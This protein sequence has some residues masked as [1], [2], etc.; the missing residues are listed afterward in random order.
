MNKMKLM[1]F[2]TSLFAL[3]G[4]HNKEI[5]ATDHAIL[6]TV[7]TAPYLQN[8]SPSGITIM[9]ELSGTE[10]CR[11]EYGTDKTH[12]QLAG[13]DYVS[14]GAGSFIY[15]SVLTQLAPGTTYHFRL[16]MGSEPQTEQ[17][18]T[19]APKGKANFVFG[20]WGD[21]Q[22]S[23]HDAYPED[24]NEPTKS[25]MSHMAEQV[26]FSVSAGD[27]CE[28][29][30]DYGSVKEFYLDRVAT[31]LGS[32]TPWFNAWGNHDKEPDSIIRKFAD[33]PSKERGE[34]YHAGYGNFSFD[35]ADCHFICIDDDYPNDTHPERWDWA[36]VE[37]DLMKA[38]AN[39]ARFIF[40]FIHRAPFYER[41]YDGEK[42]ARDNLVPLM[43][44]YGVDVC[45]SGHM[46]G[47][48]R[49]DLNGV[50]YCVTGGGSWLDFPEPLVREW[51]HMTVGG[52]H[53]LEEGISGGLINEYVKVVVNEDGF[54]ATVIAFN[55]DGTVRNQ[56][57]DT[58]S[59]RDADEK[60]RTTR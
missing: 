3:I 10:E 2:T 53:D 7:L 29:G 4:C 9:W 38:N 17:T 57:I 48:E 60:E 24:P 21:S 45:F 40:L 13:V 47:Y 19:T 59:K 56:A 58:F 28:D 23:N 32:T 25:M 44:E 46:H 54:V 39:K 36:W 5:V 37:N 55:P 31:Y 18:F 33:M 34:P 41:W 12:G 35:Y 43:E 52:Y 30:H 14:S 50:Y 16:M 42:P 51:P 15:K 22:G 11:I 49:G 8:V 6:T 1:L 20:V 27:L 26:D